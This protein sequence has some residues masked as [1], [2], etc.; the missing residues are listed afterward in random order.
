MV[1]CLIV[2][3]KASSDE[4]AEKIATRLQEVASI[5]R[6]DKE[7][8]SWLVHRDPKEPRKFA[9]VERYLNKGSLQ[10]HQAN[11]AYQKFGQWVMPLLEGRKMDLTSWEEMEVMPPN[12]DSA[13]YAKL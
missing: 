6:K 12:Q 11:P 3:C 8:L 7:T 2:H 13:A 10:Y 4:N 1:Y 5:Y 9:I